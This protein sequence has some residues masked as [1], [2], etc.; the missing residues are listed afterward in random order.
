MPRPGKLNGHEFKTQHGTPLYYS[1]P[2]VTTLSINALGEDVGE[3][4]SEIERNSLRDWL[5]AQQYLEVHPYT[6]APPGGWAWTNL[7]GGV[8]DADDTAGGSVDRLTV[9]DLGSPPYATPAIGEG[10][11]YIRTAEAL[12]AF[13]E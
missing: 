6:N 13:G 2:W 7:P 4:L 11:I 3:L 12:W 10:R 8:P 9:N 1:L 5:L